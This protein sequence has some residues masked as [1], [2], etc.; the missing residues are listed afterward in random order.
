MAVLTSIIVYTQPALKSPV[1]LP[2][3]LLS[4][5]GNLN[6]SLNIHFFSQENWL[7]VAALPAFISNTCSSA[8]CELA[9]FSEAALKF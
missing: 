3:L 9:Q 2:S 1:D 7:G 5:A 6:F 4:T 8:P